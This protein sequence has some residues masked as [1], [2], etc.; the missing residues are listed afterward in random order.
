MKRLE[1]IETSTEETLNV[2]DVAA[3]LGLDAQCVR[4]QAQTEP[5]KLGFPVIVVG[6][7]VVV[8]RRGFL[9]FMKYGHGH[10]RSAI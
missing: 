6:R 1:D 5:A 10:E 3:F 4:S 2:D 8:P 7:R 9:Y